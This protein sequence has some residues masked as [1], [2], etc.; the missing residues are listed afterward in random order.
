MPRGKKQIPNPKSVLFNRKKKSKRS[1]S[2][3]DEFK[4]EVDQ[5]TKF[6]LFSYIPFM[7]SPYLIAYSAECNG[8]MFQEYPFSWSHFLSVVEQRHKILLE[9]DG[10]AGDYHILMFS[11]AENYQLYTKNNLLRK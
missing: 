1:E 10:G 11:S 3:N 7:L 6:V 2:Q 8:R 4:D 9:G 5:C